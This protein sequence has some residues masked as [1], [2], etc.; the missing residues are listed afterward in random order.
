MNGFLI[1]A[2]FFFKNSLKR[3][4]EIYFLEMNCVMNSE[5]NS[6]IHQCQAILPQIPKT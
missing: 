2:F 5:M 6:R 4:E 3:D 1:F